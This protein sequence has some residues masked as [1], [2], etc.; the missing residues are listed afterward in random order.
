[1]ANILTCY[2]RPKPGG[3]CKR[4]FRAI[5]ALL[6]EGHNVHYLALT[7]FPIDHPNCNFHKFPWPAKKS[8]GFLFWSIFHLIAP[9]ILIFI[10][11][12]H[13]I[14]HIFTFANTYS[15]VMQPLRIMKQ[16]PSVLFLRAD[17]IKNHE[18]KQRPQWLLKLELY[19]EGLAI[20]NIR[21]YGVSD[22]LKVL[23]KR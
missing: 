2:Y 8:E 7:S 5:N 16:I 18:L 4:L 11:Y 6:S 9:I 19:F 14:S 23:G 13:H 17:S 1:M 21:L 15:L 3:L 20:A 22:S 10:G 12:K